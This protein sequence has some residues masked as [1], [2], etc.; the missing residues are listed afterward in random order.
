MVG[1]WQITCCSLLASTVRIWHGYLTATFSSFHAA[2]A[3]LFYFSVLAFFFQTIFNI[4]FSHPRCVFYYLIWSF[5]WYIYL[6]KCLY[7]GM[8]NWNRE[9][10]FISDVY[11]L[12]VA[13]LYGN[14]SNCNE[15]SVA[16]LF[17]SFFY[18]IISITI[19][20]A[21]FN[22]CW[23]IHWF[24]HHWSSEVKSFKLEWNCSF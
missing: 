7:I 5:F 17:K 22:L 9:W 18:W 1:I 8:N 12:C 23:L 3:F 11:L 24:I 14:R 21:V 15:I 10:Y 16:S 4:F 2:S 13:E 6:F 20:L 19:A